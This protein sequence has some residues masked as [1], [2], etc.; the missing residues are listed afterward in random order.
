M[1]LASNQPFQ[2]FLKNRDNRPL[3]TPGD[4]RRSPIRHY[5]PNPVAPNMIQTERIEALQNFYQPYFRR[6]DTPPVDSK[7]D[8]SDAILHFGNDGPEEDWKKGP[9]IL[10]S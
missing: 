10:V 7:N 5:A 2:S 6:K 9:V 4:F 1:I 8:S 3:S